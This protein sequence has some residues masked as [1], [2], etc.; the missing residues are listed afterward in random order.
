MRYFLEKVLFFTFYNIV[1][2]YILSLLTENN[3]ELKNNY[4]AAIID[5][6]AR[7]NEISKPKIIFAGGSNLAFGINSPEIENKFNMPVVNLGLHAGLGLSFILKELKSSLRSK[8]IVFLSIEYLI[9]SEGDYKLQNQTSGFYKKANDF[10]DRSLPKDMALHVEQTRN[11][12]KVIFDTFKSKNKLKEEQM[13]IYNRKG[14]NRNGD[15][16]S[17]LEKIRY[18]EWNENILKYRYWEGIG[19][20]NNFYDYAMSKNI[21][22]FFMYPNYPASEFKKN[23]ITINR[24][25][26]DLSKDLKIP[27][28]NKPS[29]FVLD[30]SLF[31]D[32]AYHLTK[33][34]RQKRTCILIDLLIKRQRTKG[35]WQ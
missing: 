10:Y 9:S 24:Y 20:L 32:T 28:I 31:F 2:Y 30:D 33:Q 5:K 13:V 4:M 8:D 12:I 26:N 15:L 7:I 16:I 22:I 17:H 25:A 18:T 19:E 29:D 6:H 1:L 11:N 21:K 14:F 3:H 27:I 34:G 35:E 23:E